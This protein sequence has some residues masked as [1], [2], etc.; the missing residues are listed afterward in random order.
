M[1]DNRLRGRTDSYGGKERYT[2]A[3][4]IGRLSVLIVE[5]ETIVALDVAERLRSLGYE[6]V[7]TVSSGEKAIEFIERRVPDLVLMDILLSG[8]MDGIETAQMIQDRYR[9]PIIYVS[10]YSDTRTLERA[11]T[12][13]PFGYITKPFNTRELHTAI[14]IALYTHRMERMLEDSRELLSITLANIAD[15]VVTADPGG[16]I[17]FMNDAAASL[18]G[19]TAESL[20]ERSLFAVISEAGGAAAGHDARQLAEDAVRTGKR[21]SGRL[22]LSG[23]GQDEM[24]VECIVSPLSDHHSGVVTGI[25]VVL[26]DLSEELEVREMQARLAAI[27]E[28]SQNAIIGLSPSGLVESWNRGAEQLFGYPAEEILG[29]RF[30]RLAPAGQADELPALL[31][32]VCNGS[33]VDTF[34]TVRRHRNGTLIET[35]LS[36][37]PITAENGGIIG[38]SVI[39]RDIG[40]RK[41]LEREMMQIAVRER[42]SIGQELHDNLGQQLTGILFRVG[43]LKSMLVKNV[44]KKETGLVEDI[45]GLLRSALEF[46]RNLSRGLLPVSMQPDGMADALAQ[47]A[48]HVESVYRIPVR[49]EIQ[50]EAAVT[51]ML[52]ATHLFAI[53]REAVINA[54]KHGSPSSISISFVRGPSE[55][56]LSVRDDGTGF[57]AGKSGGLGLKIMQYRSNMIGGHLEVDCAPEGGT[58]V[59]CRV[60]VQG[61]V[62]VRGGET[63]ETRDKGSE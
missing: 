44:S 8:A 34:E 52:T 17:L 14:E 1:P 16:K 40:E 49:V 47:F 2:M 39:A 18:V 25:V 30:S 32:R 42:Q 28:S 7:E 46:C 5:D 56:R 59:V 55:L 60:P 48:D 41:M 58:V 37:S 23:N 63:P 35:S 15:G 43:A 12:T 24:P 45:A 36:I 50:P 19:G 54:V 29:E 11:K 57:R 22:T 26:K 62:R 33:Q 9:I 4:G 31:E 38:I 13:H 20:A 51:E 6:Q 3:D 27:V 10:A 61:S 21:I 53:A